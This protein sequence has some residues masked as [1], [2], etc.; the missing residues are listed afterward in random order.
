MNAFLIV[1][2]EEYHWNTGRFWT[3]WKAHK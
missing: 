2:T 3:H 1:I